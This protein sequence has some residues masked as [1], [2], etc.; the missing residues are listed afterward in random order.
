MKLEIAQPNVFLA[1][2]YNEK[3]KN[4]CPIKK[5]LNNYIMTDRRTENILPRACRQKFVK[6]VK[7]ME[8]KVDSLWNLVNQSQPTI[9][10]KSTFDLSNEQ[11]TVINE[12]NTAS[13]KNLILAPF[14]QY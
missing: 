11:L 9:N 3:K 13:H 7:T 10:F 6:L 5:N 2:V 1:D 14:S 12:I 4:D 8:P